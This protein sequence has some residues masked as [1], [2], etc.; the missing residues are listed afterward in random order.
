M[1][2]IFF[3]Y[4]APQPL[5]RN[6]PTLEE[7][8]VEAMQNANL[9]IYFKRAWNDAYLGAESELVGL[10]MEILWEMCKPQD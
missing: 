10:E 7:A 5:W 9:V 8:K 3:S 1:L 2:G 4:Y 6:L